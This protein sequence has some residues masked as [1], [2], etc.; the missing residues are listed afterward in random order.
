MSVCVEFGLLLDEEKNGLEKTASD[1]KDANKRNALH[2]AA[3]E[4]KVEMCR[5]LLEELKFDVEVRDEDGILYCICKARRSLIW[6]MINVNNI[7]I[8]HLEIGILYHFI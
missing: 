6:L 1:V 4:G 3:R 7:G 2:F 8:F 5:Y